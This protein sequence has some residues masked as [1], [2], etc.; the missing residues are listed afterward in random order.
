MVA[1]VIYQGDPR[2]FMNEN[3]SFLDFRGGQPIMDAGL[4]NSVLI[5]LFTRPGWVGNTV[6]QDIEVH[7]GSDY[8]EAFNQPLTVSALADIQ[9]AAERALEWM[10]DVNLARSITVTASNDQAFRVN[11]TILIQPPDLPLVEL[12][13]IRNGVN[14]IIQRDNPASKRFS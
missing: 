4:E 3:G 5:S 14:W 10:I 8:E 9:Q 13:L 7:I 2:L 6:F 1:K 11:T 12:V